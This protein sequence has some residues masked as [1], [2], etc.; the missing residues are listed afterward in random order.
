MPMCFGLAISLA[1]I[2]SLFGTLPRI[3]RLPTHP[4]LSNQ[5]FKITQSY[6]RWWEGRVI[7]GKIIEVARLFLSQVRKKPYVV[8]ECI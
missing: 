2:S 8:I 6:N 7:L 3:Q 1:S 5:V 4:L